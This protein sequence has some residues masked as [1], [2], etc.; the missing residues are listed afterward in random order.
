ME[1]RDKEMLVRLAG[2]N[3]ELAALMTEH[4]SLES[5]LEEMNHRPYLAPEED[6]ERKKIQKAKLAVKDRIQEFLDRIPR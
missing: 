6:L 4:Q 5:R 2:E 1:S 3:P